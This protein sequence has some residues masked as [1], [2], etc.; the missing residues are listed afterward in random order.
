MSDLTTRIVPS[1]ADVAS[2]SWDALDH[3]SSPF[4]EHGFLLA[5]ERSGSVGEAAGW[6]PHYVLVERGGGAQAE[7]PWVGDSQRAEIAPGAGVME[8]VG[9]VAAYVKTHSYGEYIFDWA[10]AR[11]SERAGLAYYPK[12]VVAVPMTP[13][14]G[15][16][17]L[18]ARDMSRGPVVDR[19]V[20]A[21]RALADRRGCRSIHWL[22]TSEAE[23]AELRE[24]GFMARASFQYHWRSAGERDFEGFLQRMTSRRRKQIRK[25]RARVHAAVSPV[26]W[27]PG[28][29]LTAEDVATIDRFYRQTTM[30]HY[31]Q[32]YLQP[33]FF[34][35][36][37]ALQPGRVRWARVV[38]D[39]RT[40]AGALYWETQAALYGRYWGC[41]EEVPFLHFEAAYYAG[42]E[43]CLARGTPLFEAGAQGEHKLIRG[44][45]PSPTYSSHWFRHPG[46]SAAVERFVRDE[47]EAVRGHMRELA[48]LLPFREGDAPEGCAD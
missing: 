36:V 3:G 38:R 9:A 1:I 22:F 12:L 40:I 17:L 7:G 43:R 29:A 45:L 26:E 25:E 5:L 28:D 24:R 20:A 8:L 48:T 15:S 6:E 47:A 35:E 11:G 18:V 13:A 34:A 33:G 30:N 21:V 31:G 14:T 39:G 2:S 16:R 42:I 4:S 46:F 27:V 41:D 32:D 10:W 19:L 37:V 23:Q 44:F